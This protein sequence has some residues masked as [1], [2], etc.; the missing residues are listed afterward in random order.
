MEQDWGPYQKMIRECE[1]FSRTGLKG[2]THSK[3]RRA[4]HF[5]S[6]EQS[7]HSAMCMFALAKVCAVLFA[8]AHCALSRGCMRICTPSPY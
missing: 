6:T 8:R 2:K 3:K 1:Y 4:I 5:S 7:C